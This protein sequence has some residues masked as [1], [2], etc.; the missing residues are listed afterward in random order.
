MSLLGCC[1]SFS[2]SA[3]DIKQLKNNEDGPLDY[4]V[5]EIL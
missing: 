1:E 2:L 5:N 3:V 4:Q